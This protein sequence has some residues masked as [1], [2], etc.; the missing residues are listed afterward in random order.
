MVK[1][2]PF[3]YSSNIDVWLGRGSGNMYK[4]LDCGFQGALFIEMDE[5]TARKLEQEKRKADGDLKDP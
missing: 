4:C 2:C 1:V 3:C 5:E